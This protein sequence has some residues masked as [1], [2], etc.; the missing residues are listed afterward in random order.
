VFSRA[1]PDGATS[2]PQC[3]SAFIESTPLVA[4]ICFFVL[5][6]YVALN[7]TARELEQPFGLGANDLGLTSFQNGG[8]AFPSCVHAAMRLVVARTEQPRL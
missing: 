2:F 5:L 7:E 1:G 6:G 8:L 3:I 4:I